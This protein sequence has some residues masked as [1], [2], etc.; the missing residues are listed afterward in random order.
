MWDDVVIGKGQKGYSAI[1]MF[2][3]E[4]EHSISH[5]AVSFWIDGLLLDVG[6][7]IFKSTKEGQKLTQMIA[8][9]TPLPKIIDYL[10]KVM[11]KHVKPDL[12]Y[13][14]IN[15]VIK[16]SFEDGQHAKEQQI[17]LALGMRN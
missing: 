11:I 3:I 4:G 7:T 12:L 8:N 10:N 14:K 17:R 9:K 15:Q 1:H 6:M 13:R 5:N 16:E 2:E